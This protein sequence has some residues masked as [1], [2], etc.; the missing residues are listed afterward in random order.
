MSTGIYVHCKLQ[1][2]ES[3]VS[4]QHSSIVELSQVP[5]KA[6]FIFSSAMYRLLI[7]TLCARQVKITWATQ[8][9]PV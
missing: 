1:M 3:L 9:P 2:A 5:D 6:N 7:L 4:G 8:R